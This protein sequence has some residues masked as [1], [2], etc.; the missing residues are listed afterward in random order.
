MVN[1]KDDCMDNVDEE[2]QKEQREKVP[3]PVRCQERT[4]K[5]EISVEDGDDSKFKIPRSWYIY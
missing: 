3:V 2:E 5:E 4:D 1:V